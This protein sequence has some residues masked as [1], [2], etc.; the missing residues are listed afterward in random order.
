MNY[1]QILKRD[2][3]EWKKGVKIFN[4]TNNVQSRMSIRHNIMTNIHTQVSHATFSICSTT[5][6]QRS[7]LYTLIMLK[8][9]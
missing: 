5:H 2:R 1:C 6:T 9:Q 8:L 3:E 7:A 4:I